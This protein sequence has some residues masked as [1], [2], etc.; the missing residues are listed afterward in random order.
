LGCI[1]VAVVVLVGV[2][3]AGWWGVAFVFAIF[4]IVE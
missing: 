4:G 3:E 2:V 1:V